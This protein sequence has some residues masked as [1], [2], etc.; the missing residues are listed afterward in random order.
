MNGD[1]SVTL[2]QSATPRL[3]LHRRLLEV[4]HCEEVL[5][6]LYKQQE[7][8]TPTHFG[9]GQEAVAVG[10]CSAL[11]ADDVVYTHHRSHNHY[12]AKGGS[13]LAL[14]A[15]L[16]GRETGCSGGRGG[17]VHLTA[18]EVGFVASSA[19]LGEMVAVATGS[20]LAFQMDGSSQVA[21]SFFGEATCEEGVFHESLNYAA[22][23]KLPVLYVCENNLYSTE[24]AL[25]V[26]QPAGLDLCERARAF[27]VKARR[28]DGNDVMAVYDATQELLEVLRTGQGPAFLECMTY[29]WLEHVGPNFDHDMGRDYRSREEVEIWMQR[30]PV[31]RSAAALIADGM[32][33]REELERM[34]ADVAAATEAAAVQ[35]R[36]A[37]FPTADRLFENVW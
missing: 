11:R 30:C 20:A 10:V 28:V 34:N 37:P 4:R 23:K 31:K 9:L 16:Y 32:A 2:P 22:I 33:T 18:R 14:A 19:I 29:R 17:S 15:E 35:A 21:V 5:A 24:S 36:R 25:T 3:E 12:I 6:R 7:M 27:R 13:F 1:F 26:R 8:R